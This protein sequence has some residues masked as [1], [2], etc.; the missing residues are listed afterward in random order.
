MLLRSAAAR[1][2]RR[3]LHANPR[4]SND[5][6]AT[7]ERIMDFLRG[8]PGVSVIHRDVGGGHGLVYEVRGGDARSSSATSSS[9]TVPTVLL[10]SDMDALPLVEDSGVEHTSIVPNAHH[11]CGHDGHSAML[12]AALQRLGEHSGDGS[13]HGR[14]VGVFQP[15]EETGDG[16]L[17]M[18]EALRDE[19]GAPGITHG[20][21]GIHNIPG[22][23]LGQVCLL[24]T[25]P[26]PR[27]RG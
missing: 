3:S 10:R 1:E 21:F 15:A 14:V 26:S 12:A 19:L 20:A 8:S 2:L 17:Q 5:E 27:D 25:S 4:V 22:A 13:W 18:L 6:G 24:Y 16:A 11:A 9:S 7:V 23:P